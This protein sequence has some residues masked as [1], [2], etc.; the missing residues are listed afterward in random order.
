MNVATIILSYLFLADYTNLDSSEEDDPSACK[1]PSPHKSSS[2]PAPPPPPP[3]DDPVSRAPSKPRPKNSEHMY[4]TSKCIL[5][6]LHS[7]HYYDGRV[8]HFTK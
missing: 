6:V 4:G 1:I 5:L 2:I 8:A 3:P 7:K